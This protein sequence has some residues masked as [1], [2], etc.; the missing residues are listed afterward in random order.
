MQQRVMIA[1]ALAC[2]PI[3]LLADEPT[4][5]L[6]V[7]TQAQI[8]DLI[9]RLAKDRG[10]ATILITHDLGVAASVNDRTL[11]MYAGEAVE[12]GDTVEVFSAPAMPYTEALLASVPSPGQLEG[13][14]RLTSIGGTLP[15]LSSTAVGCRFAARCVH[16]R[17]ICATHHPELTP[18]G[19]GAHLARCFSTEVNGWREPP[20][21]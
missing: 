16:M 18:R 8:L 14:E 20:R 19:A 13:G 5:A 1:M 12:F 7:T 2:D 4:S 6:D 17:E 10:M 15:D 9:Q 21:S 11:I 3:L